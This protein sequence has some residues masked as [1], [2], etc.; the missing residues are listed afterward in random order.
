[1]IDRVLNLCNK[2]RLI[3]HKEAECCDPRYIALLN[4]AKQYLPDNSEIKVR[5]VHV[6]NKI[7]TLIQLIS[8]N[9]IDIFAVFT[10]YHTNTEIN[11][12]KIKWKRHL[13]GTK[14]YSHAYFSS[15]FKISIFLT[16]FLRT[17]QKSILKRK[18]PFTA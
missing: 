15:T 9:I 3:G 18:V 1:M 7:R 2:D 4:Y 16:F 10:G 6:I 5:L 12:K 11:D 8:P 14:C 17:M 13:P